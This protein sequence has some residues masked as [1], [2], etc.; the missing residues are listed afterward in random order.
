ML[1]CPLSPCPPKRWSQDRWLQLPGTRWLALSGNPKL[2]GLLDSPPV[3]MR[4]EP[5]RRTFQW[6]H[7]FALPGPK[8]SPPF[9]NPT[10]AFQVQHITVNL[11]DR[12]LCLPLFLFLSFS[13]SLSL[14]LC[15]SL[16][17][18]VS[19]SL[20]NQA[21]LWTSRAGPQDIASF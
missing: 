11:L 21:V 3:R 7:C 13:L 14:S 16:S 20:S 15:L 10:R 17:L 18:F 12:A 6:R 8:R 1:L 4:P 9:L 19:L 2:G 5:L